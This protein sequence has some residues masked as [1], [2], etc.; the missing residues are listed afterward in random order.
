VTCLAGKGGPLIYPRTMLLEWCPFWDPRNVTAC[1]HN[2][3][4]F[5]S[6][7]KE[8]KA[9][10]TVPSRQGNGKDALLRRNDPARGSNTESG[11]CGIGQVRQTALIPKREGLSTP[12]SQPRARGE[13][14]FR[15]NADTEEEVVAR[16]G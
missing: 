10:E 4:L 7:E 14:A 16:E 2:Q 11:K 5:L 8:R 9:E 13:N 12:L 1:G 15:K 6:N 3:P